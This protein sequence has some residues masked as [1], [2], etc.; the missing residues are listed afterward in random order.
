MPLWKLIQ[1]PHQKEQHWKQHKEFPLLSSQLP[2]FTPLA[3]HML[4]SLMAN[5]FNKLLIRKFVDKALTSP[6][7]GILKFC[8]HFGHECSLESARSLNLLEAVKAK[9]VQTWQLLWISEL[10]HTHRTGY[11]FMKIV[12]QGLNI[13]D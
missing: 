3:C 2:H 11:F 7:P 13:H 8:L 9:A 12:Q 10:G 6:S 4:H 1:L 5:T